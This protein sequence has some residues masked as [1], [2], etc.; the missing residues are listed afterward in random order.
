MARFRYKMQ[1]ILDV[2]L[3]LET[4]C[5]QE[6]ADAKLALEQEIEK[7][8]QL[9]HRKAEY[10]AQAQEN[11]MGKLNLLEMAELK[12]AILRM[13]EYIFL[14]TQ[15]V[16]QAENR[17]EAVRQRLEETIKERKVHERLK[18]K[19]FEDFLMEEKHAE[20]KEIDELTSYTYGQKG[21]EEFADS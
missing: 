5:K 15:E 11:R 18:E 16:E 1:S 21:K 17:L 13:D 20:S 19:A 7:L 4:Q 3:K 9:E 10:E 12:E 6:F 2:T 8:T 14:Q